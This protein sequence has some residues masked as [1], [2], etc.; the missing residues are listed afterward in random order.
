MGHGD[1]RGRADR[2]CFLERRGYACVSSLLAT[3]IRDR[4]ERGR[5]G[6]RRA[7]SISNNTGLT[8][9]FSANALQYVAMRALREPDAF[10]VVEDDLVRTF[11]LSSPAEIRERS[12]AWRPWRAYAVACLCGS[13]QSPISQSVSRDALLDASYRFSAP[14]VFARGAVHD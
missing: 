6:R 12:R 4:K 10:P 2:R 14:G 13:A 3:A 1:L 8:Q 7:G 5:Q 9:G 11:A